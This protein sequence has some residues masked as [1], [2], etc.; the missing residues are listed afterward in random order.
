MKLTTKRT[1]S[2]AAH[3]RTLGSL[4]QVFDAASVASHFTH[5]FALNHELIATTTNIVSWVASWAPAPPH[6]PPRQNLATPIGGQLAGWITNHLRVV[7][8][9]LLISLTVAR[10]LTISPSN[11][12][13]PRRWSPVSLFQSHRKWFSIFGTMWTVTVEMRF[14]GL[15]YSSEDWM[16]L[17]MMRPER[18]ITFNA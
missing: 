7:N 17:R 18:H 15:C 16:S 4:D 3:H 14:L 12:T 6:P 8:A 13:C 10:R 2:T 11:Y 5:A 1:A 9:P